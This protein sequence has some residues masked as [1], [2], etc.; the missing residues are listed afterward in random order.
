VSGSVEVLYAVAFGDAQTGVAVGSHGAALLT[1]DGGTTWTRAATGL[2]GYL[3]AAV[4]TAPHTVLV[5]GEG[6]L[7]LSRTLP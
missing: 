4:F 2:D 3:G 7:V 1:T 6:G 5:G